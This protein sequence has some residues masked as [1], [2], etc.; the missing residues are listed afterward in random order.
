MTF[1]PGVFNLQGLVGAPIAI[2]DGYRQATDP[3]LYPLVRWAGG[4]SA[5]GQTVL[6]ASGFGVPLAR[7]FGATLFR[8]ETEG[9]GIVWLRG[10]APKE[11]PTAGTGGAPQVPLLSAQAA[12]PPPLPQ[13]LPQAPP[14]VPLATTPAAEAAAPR[15]LTEAEAKLYG[16]VS[17]PQGFREQVWEMS[18]A[19]DGNV[20][21]PTG[22]ILKFDEP[23]ELGHT[24]AN[25][26]SDAQL[27]AAQ[28]G[29]DRKT[30]IRY[31]N[32]P[33][34][35]RPELPSSNTSHKWE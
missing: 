30:W 9:K 21:D 19:P 10:G 14:S 5:G 7:R 2:R 13:A 35:Y 25:K 26:F 15:A 32:D 22:R 24:P 4:L 34:I 8:A 29:W 6:L 20:Y 28:E 12:K 33:A 3:N 27:R 1:S 31:Q 16:R 17:H 11:V 23:L 18:K